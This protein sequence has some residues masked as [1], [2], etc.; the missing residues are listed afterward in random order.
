[1]G[2]IFT[3]QM[4]NVCLHTPLISDISQSIS[5]SVTFTKVNCITHDKKFLIKA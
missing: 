5:Q 4:L 3:M 1:M 2:P